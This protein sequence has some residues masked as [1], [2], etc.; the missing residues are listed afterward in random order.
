MFV[1]TQSS[2]SLGSF[3][4]LVPPTL[5]TLGSPAVSGLRPLGGGRKRSGG[6]HV[7]LLWTRPGRGILTSAHKPF[8]VAQ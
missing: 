1:S 3:L 4:F 5:D 7:R 8:P 6:L 2:R